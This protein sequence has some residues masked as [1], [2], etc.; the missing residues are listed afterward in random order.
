MATKIVEHSKDR[1]IVETG[2]PEFMRLLMLCAAVCILVAICMVLTLSKAWRM[3][4]F[5]GVLLAAAFF[6]LIFLILFE[7]SVFIFDCAT[8][9]LAWRKRRAFSLAAGD[10]KFQEVKD[11]LIQT[12][13]G[14][15]ANPKRRIALL[16]AEGELPLSASYAPDPGGVS[17]LVVDAI[18]GALGVDR[19]S[20]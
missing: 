4:V 3:E 17:E 2:D 8:S 6:I 15:P 20:Q 18:K 11:V 10:I 12:S 5:Q 14:D 13:I 19:Q 9:R 16:C 7:H 1:L